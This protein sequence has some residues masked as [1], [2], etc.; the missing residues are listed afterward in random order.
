MNY[1]KKTYVISVG[2]AVKRLNPQL[3][4]VGGLQ[5]QITERKAER[6][7]VRESAG[8]ETG[9]GGLAGGGPVAR[10]A[11]T[12]FR[13]RTLDGDN[14]IGGFK[15]L[16]DAVARWLGCDDS[17]RFI[18]WEYGQVMTKGATGTVVRIEILQ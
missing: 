14:L 17:E 13:R 6:A 7:L 12:A 11:L 10:V 4:G 18:E 5:P 16:R 15:P 2:E 9:G 3:F 1:T 8:R